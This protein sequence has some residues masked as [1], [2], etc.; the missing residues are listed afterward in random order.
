MYY[1]NYY[2]KS[3]YAEKTWKIKVKKLPWWL[4]DDITDSKLPVQLNNL[5]SIIIEPQLDHNSH[6]YIMNE[7]I[8]NIQKY[9]D[10]ELY[11]FY[12]FS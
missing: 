10:F 9:I 5:E 6:D 12:K 4:D 11:S 3:Y 1:N 7:L 8:H 2:K